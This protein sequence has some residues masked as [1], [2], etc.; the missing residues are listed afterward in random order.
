MSYRLGN[1]ENCLAAGD[2]GL[3]KLALELTS[4]SNIAIRS[5]LADKIQILLSQNKDDVITA[6][7][8]QCPT[9]GVRR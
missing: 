8:N 1:A 5:L 3:L 4:Q 9:D 2:E 6:S 7:I